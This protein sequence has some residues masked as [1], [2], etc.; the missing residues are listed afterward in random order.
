MILVAGQREIRRLGVM[1]VEIIESGEVNVMR[2]GGN[3]DT[4]SFPEAQ[5]QLSKLIE[6]GARKILLDLKELVYISSAGLRVFLIAAK[7]L[8]QQGGELRVSN[9]NDFVQEVFEISGFSKIFNVFNS[10]AEA[11]KDF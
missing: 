3:L 1:D 2:I 11:L 9:L 7:Q 6:Q 5:S 10:E 8:K 4:D